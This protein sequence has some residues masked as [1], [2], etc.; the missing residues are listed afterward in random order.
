M[1]ADYDLDFNGKYSE[2]GKGPFEYIGPVKQT[3]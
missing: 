3:F 2:A 1:H